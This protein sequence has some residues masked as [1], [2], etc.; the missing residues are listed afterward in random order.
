MKMTLLKVFPF[1]LISEESQ[2]LDHRAPLLSGSSL[3]NS[4]TKE[5]FTYHYR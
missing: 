5:S 4:I 3:Q 2:M 1:T